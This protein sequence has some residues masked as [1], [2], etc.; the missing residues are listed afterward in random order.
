MSRDVN[1]WARLVCRAELTVESRAHT[2]T[3]Q[4]RMTV[5]ILGEGLRR[6]PAAPQKGGHGADTTA[7]NWATL[8]GA[9]LLGSS[10]GREHH[11]HHHTPAPPHTHRQTRWRYNLIIKSVAFPHDSIQGISLLIDVHGVFFFLVD[12]LPAFLSLVNKQ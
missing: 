10:G 11:H 7:G 5:H 2:R 3:R 4:P 1:G 9:G 12:V 8:A 6:A